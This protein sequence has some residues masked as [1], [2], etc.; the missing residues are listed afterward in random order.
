MQFQEKVKNVLKNS[1]LDKLAKT[2]KFIQRSTSRVTG[3]DIIK[4]MVISSVDSSAS[5][6]ESLCCAIA[7][8]NHGALL[9]RQALDQRLHAPESAC[10]FQKAFEK[11]LTNFLP[12]MVRILEEIEES[13]KVSL[14]FFKHIHIQDSTIMQLHE[15]LQEYFKG[16]GGSSKAVAVKIDVIYEYFTRT[17]ASLTITDQGEPDQALSLRK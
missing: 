8:I 15:D 12:P 1:T 16:S 11:V 13:S 5:S 2:C 10:F 7:E 6:L 14:N 17:I 9:T 3:S 4:A